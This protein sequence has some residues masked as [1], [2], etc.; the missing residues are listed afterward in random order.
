LEQTTQDIRFRLLIDNLAQINEQTSTFKKMLADV[1][2]VPSGETLMSKMGKDTDSALMKLKTYE[3]QLAALR[4]K[5]AKAF[6][7]GDTAGFDKYKAEYDSL[8][9]KMVDFN[10]HFGIFHR[11]FYDS[12]NMWDYAMSKARSHANWLIT[13]AA[14][15]G[16]TALSQTFIANA[17]AI[18]EQLGKTRQNM[19]LSPAYHDNIAQLDADMLHLKDTAALFSVA[20]SADLKEV[21]ESMQLLS[22]RYKDISTIQYLE[23]LVLTL[24]KLDFLPIKEGSRLIEAIANQFQLSAAGAKQF[25]NE[26]S[27]ASHSYNVLSTDLLSAL[28]RSGSALHQMNMG[29][30]ESIALVSVLSNASSKAGG[31]IGQALKSIS[32]NLD[33]P[34]MK[35]ALNE[36]GISLYDAENK[37]RPGIEVLEDM[38]RRFGQMDEKSQNAFSTLT[39]GGKYQANFASILLRQAD[40]IREAYNKLGTANDELTASLLATR[41]DT[42]TNRV[43]QMSSAWQVFSTTIGYEVLPALKSLVWSLSEGLQALNN[44]REEV[45]KAVT[46]ITL[47]GE[48]FLLSKGSTWLFTAAATAG[49]G[50]LGGVVG[51]AISA[52]L[53]AGNLRTGLVAL[54]S[55]FYGLATGVAAAAGRLVVFIG[56]AQILNNLIGGYQAD[57]AAKDMESRIHDERKHADREGISQSTQEDIKL[58]E[59]RNVLLKEQKDHFL[60][61]HSSTL[62]DDYRKVNN[63]LDAVNDAI[64][65]RN[66]ISTQMGLIKRM[67]EIDPKAT[68]LQDEKNKSGGDAV[69]FG[70]GKKGSG[71]SRDPYKLENVTIHRAMNDAF[72]AAKLSAD[73]YQE[74]LDNLSLKEKLYGSTI[75]TAV[76]SL[77]I[78][79]QRQAELNKEQENYNALAETY[80]EA[81]QEMID[82]DSSLT[83]AMKNY[84]LSLKDLGKEEYRTLIQDNN[85]L[86]KL[87][88]AYNKLAEAASKAAKEGNKLR[89]DT[90]YDKLGR[91]GDPEYMRG[92][93]MEGS[94]AQTKWDKSQLDKTN[95]T[96]GRDA[97][98]L[99]LKDATYQY[100]EYAKALRDAESEL[101]KLT[102]EHSDNLKEI[103]EQTK[104]VEQLKTATADSYS[105]MKDAAYQ[106]GHYTKQFLADTFIDLAVEGNTFEAIM[107]KIW[108]QVAKEAIYAMLG[109][110]QQATMLNSI[111]GMGG[112]GKGGGS[113]GVS[114]SSSALRNSVSNSLF[115]STFHNGGVIPKF[116]SG[117]VVP[118]LKKS[119]TPAILEQG[120]EINSRSERRSNELMA[121]VMKVLAANQ[122]S[123]VIQI[124]AMDSKSFIEFANQHGEA[125][126]NL[127]RKQKSLGNKV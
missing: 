100:Q 58:L 45:H 118:Y 22:R 26:V 123:S 126:V 6:M 83:E 44:H 36:L 98:I 13:G 72:T 103:D 41:L 80:K 46:G 66:R 77:T 51:Q 63:E 79:K 75:A 42:F 99:A 124:Q 4:Q 7:V 57:S 70:N 93:R 30:R 1:K 113:L 28:Q 25:V 8:D 107:K 81:A 12:T 74:S 32:I 117:G 54:A 29:T 94:T 122:S 33:Y 48:A 86:S 53:A 61:G 121:D 115:K 38:F 50:A 110:Q 78:K 24:H 52:Q 67:G 14:L 127:L 62:N 34:K 101:K 95:V 88:D 16:I 23:N 65:S 5:S 37:M 18:E 71:A 60:S 91:T 84:G 102:V 73:R 109:I 105:K 116:H 17:K 64:S 87:L 47:L 120:E 119:E 96:Y 35:K 21:T 69:D 10:K 40:M 111:M 11:G 68:V 92:R 89:N 59:K 108:S 31:E 90:L 82:K 56:L 39:G 19:E 104:K 125:F 3:S 20:Y 76:E 49:A 114:G 106:Y 85:Y 9:K 27:L 112:K 55:N 43:E 97:E 15:G 2:N